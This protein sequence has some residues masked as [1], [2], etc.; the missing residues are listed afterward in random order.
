MLTRFRTL[1]H[2]HAGALILALC[3]GVLCSAPAVYFSYVAPGYSGITMMGSDAEEYYTARIAEVYAGYPTLGNV[4]LPQ[5]DQPYFAPGLGERIVADMGMTLGLSPSSVVV[6]SKFIFPFLTVLLVYA[7][8]YSFCASTIGALLA[9][10]LVV[11]GDA[12]FYGSTALWGVI[13][14]HAPITDFLLYSRPIN[15]EVSSL[16]LFSALFI[17]YRFFLKSIQARRGVTYAAIVALGLLA[18]GSLYTSVYV[19][20][21]LLTILGLSALWSLFHKEY[22]RTSMLFASIVIGLLVL[23]PFILNFIQLHQNALFAESSIR[24][25]L[26]N[27]HTPIIGFWIIA[28]FV[29]LLFWPRRFIAAR[30]FFA[31]GVTSILILLNQQIVTGIALQSAHYHWYITRPFVGMVLA[32][33]VVFLTEQLFLS[34]IVRGVLYFAGFSLLLI[35]AMIVQRDSYKAQYV[36]TLDVQAYAPVLSFLQTLSG[37]QSV[38]A[39]RNLSLYIPIYTKQ[40]TPNN[41]V[42]YY[43]VSQTFLENRLFLEYSLRKISPA[44]ALTTMQSEREDISKRLFG[45]Y[46]RDQHDSYASIPDSILEQYASDYQT[47]A[48]RSAV[49]Q[50]GALGIS[51]VVWDIQNDPSWDISHV[52]GTVPIFRTAR[53]EVYQLAT[54]TKAVP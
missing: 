34:K 31:I 49:T 16:F 6:F 48:R 40:D 53:F 17:L 45:I 36:K 50:L 25:G 23:V 15:P 27:T 54:T 11:L 8:V 4:F 51:V 24:Q 46:W 41:Y 30:P 26:V 42:E 35:S 52:L 9:A 29:S 20:S 13:S 7:L 33:F 18:G 44:V 32:L 37:G 39:D 3:A 10:A 22:A 28:L 14:G 1:L 2:A 19:S 43:L 5:K 12:F 47:T 21:F 38:W